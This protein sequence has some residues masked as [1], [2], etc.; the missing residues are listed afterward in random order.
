M[1][2]LKTERPPVAGTTEGQPSVVETYGNASFAHRSAAGKPDSIA[3]PRD[4]F[5]RLVQSAI[6]L[7]DWMDGDADLEPDDRDT[8]HD[9]REPEGGL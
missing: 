9:G 1:I 4:A 2:D 6:D 8:G 5:E 3:I 7:L